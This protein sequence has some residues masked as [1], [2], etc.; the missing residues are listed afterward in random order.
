MSA[1]AHGA[2]VTAALLDAAVLVEQAGVGGLL[3]TC[4]DGHACISVPRQC[5]DARSRAALVAAL[6]LQAGAASCQ[7][8]D[9]GGRHGPAAWLEATA[10]TGVTGIEITTHLDVTAV[11]G[12]TLATGPDGQQDVIAAGQRLPDRWRW[13]TDLDD[14][15]PGQRAVVA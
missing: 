6:A 14:D 4:Y 2:A 7:R 15:D 11:P 5:G 8:H 12:G 3:V 10:R 13:V 1:H 9:Y